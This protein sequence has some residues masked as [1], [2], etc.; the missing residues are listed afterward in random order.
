MSAWRQPMP[1]LSKSVWIS[2]VECAPGTPNGWPE[3]TTTHWPS[4]TWGYQCIAGTQTQYGDIIVH[5]TCTNGNTQSTAA[6]ASASLSAI[7]QHKR[8]KWKQW[9]CC[10]HSGTD[11]NRWIV[12]AR[13]TTAAHRNWPRH[14]RNNGGKGGCRTRRQQ[15]QTCT[16]SIT[17]Q[18][19][20]ISTRFQ[21]S[22]A[23][24]DWC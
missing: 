12:V 21:L 2:S 6:T 7:P 13:S 1:H 4:P 14:W 15:R 11:A 23:R 5:N 18:T 24:M 16:T 3:R 17:S 10:D 20:I 19:S 9:H 8:S 22:A